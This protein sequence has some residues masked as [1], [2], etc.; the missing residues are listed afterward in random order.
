MDT[1]TIGTLTG[2]ADSSKKKKDSV[3]PGDADAF[4]SAI[5]E[6]AESEG[7]GDKKAELINKDESAKEK[8]DKAVA[9][10][11]REKFA[12]RS[13]EIDSKKAKGRHAKGSVGDYLKNISSKDPATLSMA[14]RSAFRLGEFSG[15]AS[16]SPAGGM[17]QMLAQ[18]GIDM[19][20]FSPQQIMSLMSRMD[21][22]E[23]GEMMSQMNMDGSKLDEEGLAQLKEQVTATLKNTGKEAP[24]NFQMDNFMSAGLPKEAGESAR[25]EQRRN[26]MDQLITEIQVRNVANQTEMQ[27]RLNPEYLGDVKIKLTHGEDGKVKANFETTSKLTSEIL[28]ESKDELMEQARDNGVSI[29]SMDVS[30][31]DEITA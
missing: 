19:S 13:K 20:G 24:A 15:K 1:N 2:T 7:D 14:E 3:N 5:G 10:E 17:A 23:L 8:A 4:A 22:K 28:A 29:A 6:V 31:V 16:A 18:Q 21:T 9:D 27:L 11:K 12:D 25:A 26:V 30:Y